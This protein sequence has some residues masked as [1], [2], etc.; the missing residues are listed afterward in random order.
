MTKHSKSAQLLAWI[1]LI[2]LVTFS[3][4]AYLAPTA[5]GPSTTEENTD[6]QTQE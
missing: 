4:L 3:I 1:A 5:N 2:I 6:T